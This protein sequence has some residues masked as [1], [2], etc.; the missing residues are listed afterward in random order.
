M[1]HDVMVE[2]AQRRE[3]VGVVSSA[4]IPMSNVVGL[5]AGGRTATVGGTSTVSS[6]HEM[7]CPPRNC[8]L[9]GA[10]RQWNALLSQRSDLNSRFTPEPLQRGGTNPR[11]ANDPSTRLTVG[12]DRIPSVD[13]DRRV[14]R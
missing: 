1:D 11:S 3:I 10:N 14:D 2:P 13:D 5:E 7:S 4:L 6:E 12:H 9:R 8:G